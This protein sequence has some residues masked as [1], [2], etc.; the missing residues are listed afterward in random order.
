MSILLPGSGPK[1]SQAFSPAFRDCAES[2]SMKWLETIGSS[3]SQSAVINVKSWLS[4]GALDAIG[5]GT[6][7]F[8]SP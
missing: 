8:I 7:V 3:N 1:E 5:H 2:I 4:R 6:I